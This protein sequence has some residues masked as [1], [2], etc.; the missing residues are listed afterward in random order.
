MLK[1]LPQHETSI[2]YNLLLWSAQ[3]NIICILETDLNQ[4][5]VQLD[6]HSLLFKQPLLCQELLTI[7]QQEEICK[8]FKKKNKEDL[9]CIQSNKL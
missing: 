4:L 6:L 2:N 9:D 8:L 7:K 3:P 1:R 5:S